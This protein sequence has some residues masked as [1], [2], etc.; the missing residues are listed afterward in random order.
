MEDLKNKTGIFAAAGRRVSRIENQLQMKQG[1]NGG[2][3]KLTYLIRRRGWNHNDIDTDQRQCLE[4]I[5][6]VRAFHHI[7]AT[8][9]FLPYEAHPY[10][11]INFPSFSTTVTNKRKA[12]TALIL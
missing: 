7:L 5:A 2:M 6:E 3:F 10:F 4:N 9:S 11:T 12:C 1:N 8:L